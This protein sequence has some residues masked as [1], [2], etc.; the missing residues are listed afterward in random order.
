VA[1]N[2]FR[3]KVKQKD[4]RIICDTTVTGDVGAVLSIPFTL[5]K[6]G[7]SSLS[8]AQADLFTISGGAVLL[9]DSSTD[10]TY[11]VIL[12]AIETATGQPATPKVLTFIVADTAALPTVTLNSVTPLT[13]YTFEVDYTGDV[14]YDRYQGALDADY[15][16]AGLF[17]LDETDIITVATPGIDYDVQVRGVISGLTEEENQYS[18][19]SNMLNVELDEDPGAHIPATDADNADWYNQR[20]AVNCHFNFNSPSDSEWLP[21]NSSG[22]I[23][24]L[25]T[26]GIRNVRTSF[27]TGG[28]STTYI[29]DLNT[30]ST[31]V[32]TKFLLLVSPKSNTPN[33]NGGLTGNT[34]VVSSL[35]N[36]T[37]SGLQTIDTIAGATDNI[38]LCMGQTAPA[39][40]GVYRMKSGAWVRHTSFD[41]WT[42]LYDKSVRTSNISGMARPNR[43]YGT[44]IALGGTLGTTAVTWA[45]FPGGSILYNTTT[46]Q[47]LVNYAANTLGA[48]KLIGFS[49]PNEVN[50]GDGDFFPYHW[51]ERTRA[52]QQSFYT[53]V[54]THPTLAIRSVPVGLFSFYGRQTVAMEEMIALGTCE[55]MCDFVEL[56]NYTGAR[57]PTEGG[58]PLSSGGGDDGDPF[59]S[60]PLSQTIA[61]LQ[62]VAPGKDVWCGEVGQDMQ[63]SL[64]PAHGPAF[65]ITSTTGASKY[66]SRTPLVYY[67]HDIKMTT[68]YAWLNNW[69]DDFHGM[70]NNNKPVS[71]TAGSPANTGPPFT[72]NESMFGTT[73][74]RQLGVMSDPGVDF[75]TTPFAY[76]FT[77]AG[78]TGDLLHFLFQKRNGKYFLMC[79][80]NGNSWKRSSPVGDVAG[81]GAEVTLTFGSSVTNVKWWKPHASAT[82]TDLGAGQI[83]EFLTGELG[84]IPDYETILEI[85]P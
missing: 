56:H 62:A 7:D 33:L 57:R 59:A 81:L 36:L 14:A 42:E 20:I 25:K 35:T 50:N 82:A 47:N 73:M 51:A 52:F 21:A 46:M 83:F 1:N 15:G 31:P 43:T 80:Y 29:N 54:K 28:Q 74:M 19:W 53:F 78:A 60:V 79:H 58:L 67:L 38:V 26:S 13:A 17:S 4:I 41:T 27:L 44:T 75:A 32:G 12:N 40:N 18:A 66:M 23:T 70:L 8:G 39:Q 34:R 55:G 11:V 5:S 6:A 76:E 3:L 37:L 9:L 69:T 64:A 10:G 63:S 65:N 77:G 45:Y 71:Q 49:G 61:E 85:T 30:N 72:F 22:W 24:P 2:R 68:F 16:A 48:T 84:P